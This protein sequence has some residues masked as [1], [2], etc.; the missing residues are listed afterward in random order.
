MILHKPHSLFMCTLRC[1][2]PE[3]RDLALL[4]LLQHPRKTPA[5][6]DKYLLKEWIHIQVFF[7]VWKATGSCYFEKSLFFIDLSNF[8]HIEYL[9]LFCPLDWLLNVPLAFYFVCAISLHLDIITFYVISSI[10][11]FLVPLLDTMFRNSNNS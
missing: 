11:L 10:I 4:P 6:N 2:F 5:H 7:C 3:S 8:T 1:K 9:L